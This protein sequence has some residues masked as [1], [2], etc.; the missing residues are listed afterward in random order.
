M[1]FASH[2]LAFRPG[3]RME[4]ESRIGRSLVAAGLITEKHLA[5][6]EAARAASPERPVAVARVEKTGLGEERVVE[7]LAKDYG[8]PFLHLAAA[9]F[10]PHALALLSAAEAKRWLAIPV[11]FDPQGVV[12]V[13]VAD[14]DTRGI[15]DALERLG[16]QVEFALATPTAIR[17]AIEVHY[18]AETCLEEILERVPE[19]RDLVVIESA[20]GAIGP[21]DLDR[22]ESE[23]VVKTVNVLLRDAIER[24][25]RDVTI[26][27]GVAVL[28]VRY[29]IDGTLGEVVRLPKWMHAVLVGR[30]RSLAGLNPQGAEGTGSEEGRFRLRVGTRD[31]PVAVSMVDTSNGEKIVLTIFD[32]MQ[33]VGE[34]GGLGLPP[35][36]EAMLARAIA[37]PHG[38]VLVAGPPGHGKKTTLHAALRAIRARPLDVVSIED[39]VETDVPGVTQVSVGERSG[40]TYAACLRTVL[41]QDPHAVVIE[42]LADR[43][44]AVA[45]FEA[46]ASGRLVLAAIRCADAARAVTRL[47]ELGVAPELLARSLVLVLAQRLVRRTCDACRTP[48]RPDPAVLAALGLPESD[49]SYTA[50]GGCPSCGGTGFRGRTILSEVLAVDAAARDALAGRASDGAIRKLVRSEGPRASLIEE[51]ARAVREGRT[52]AAEVVRVIEVGAAAFRCPSCGTELDED[53]SACP[54][55]GVSRKNVCANC[56]QPLRS[57]WS[58]C[59]YCC[60]PVARLGGA[61]PLPPAIAAAAAA[62]AL[63]Y[64]GPSAAGTPPGGTPPT[65]QG[66]NVLLA[67]D[68]EII[69]KLLTRYLRGSRR[70]YALE[71]ATNGR[72]ALERVKTFKPALVVLDIG[73]P[74]V[75]GLEVYQRLRSDLATAFIPVILLAKDDEEIARAQALKIG[76]DELIKKP[77]D[78]AEFGKRL[79]RLLSRTYGL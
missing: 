20:A 44:T 30:L 46:A 57:A 13:A 77:F 58:Y 15:R 68:E 25:A 43:K 9:T 56:R 72:E 69:R 24:R 75:D 28:R 29:K 54:G 22:T 73:M 18:H 48:D 55:C 36:H 35:E 66:V 32:P 21:A 53:F 8:L 2:V 47:F 70:S 3:G 78:L 17:D 63:P 26:E 14:P 60:V 79:D 64:S 10:D 31:I 7:A 71:T 33:T 50:G 1:T 74:K 5:E 37:R 39:P 62:A 41:R 45:A 51:A 16:L 6:A 65:E 42:D 4:A 76:S 38:L 23:P 40:Q 12:I 67:D 52:T 34:L 19:P 11:T 27:P 61:T 49:V 59:P